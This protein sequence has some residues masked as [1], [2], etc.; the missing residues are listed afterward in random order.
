MW[1]WVQILTASNL[2]I[3]AFSKTPD[4]GWPFTDGIYD[5]S[6]HLASVGI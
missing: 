4:A 1:D 6:L 5:T 3:L 2:L